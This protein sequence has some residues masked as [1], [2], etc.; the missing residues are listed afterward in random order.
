MWPF[1]RV[2]L[3]W[4]IFAWFWIATASLVLVLFLLWIQYKNSISFYD[5]APK[6]EKALQRIESI[7]EQ[8]RSARRE[9]REIHRLFR[10][11]K[12][13]MPLKRNSQVGS[14]TVFPVYELNDVGEDTQQRNVP[15]ALYLLHQKRKQFQQIHSV[16]HRD[17]VFSG[18]VK[19][20]TEEG[21]RY[22]YIAQYIGRFSS[23]AIKRHLTAF[24]PLQIIAV[25][26]A[27]LL[28]C[29]FLTWSMVK[30][31]RKLQQATHQLAVGKQV[32]AVELLGGRKD[33]FFELAN[34]FDNMSD[35][36]F[37]LI[38]T[39]KQLI[40]DVSHEL[41]SPLTRLQMAAGILEKKLGAEYQ[42]DISRIEK[43]CEQ[44]D[45]M[46]RQLL[47]I[48]A[49]ERG[50]I[51]EQADEFCVSQLLTELLNDMAFEAQ[52]KNIHISHQRLNECLM[53]GYY[54][55]L[56]SALENIIRNAIRYSPNDSQI[57]ITMQML[58]KE[59]FI[60]ICDQG[61]GIEQ[62]YLQQIFEPFFRTD[63]A[64]ARVHGGTGLGLA[65]AAK[66]IKAHHGRIEATNR[67]SGGLCIS[68]SFPLPQTNRP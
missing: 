30:P 66:A 61:P 35:K 39:Q 9:N 51:Y 24:R 58:N 7:I 60:D 55:L 45:D 10:H 18:P 2:S 33:E 31:I 63:E 23:H 53:K 14:E 21:E 41:R 42:S 36:V 37:K 48:A 25:V 46:I 50:Q 67:A 20:I 34:D 19:R 28:L 22:I 65:I 27:S 16:F 43:E 8:N 49:L 4:R 5:T 29:L 3:F 56:R 44:L 62:A 68:V 52:E 13:R 17:Y 11:F 15:E 6:V 26:L 40:S 57:D 12:L 59:C 64:R 32:S 54:H 38:E 1:N 47:D